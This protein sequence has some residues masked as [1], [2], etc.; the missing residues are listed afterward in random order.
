MMETEDQVQTGS[1]GWVELGFHCLYGISY[2]GHGS[3]LMG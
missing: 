2:G 3:I 1:S